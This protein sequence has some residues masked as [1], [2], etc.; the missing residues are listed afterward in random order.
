MGEN[1]EAKFRV[2]VLCLTFER[3]HLGGVCA[4][5]GGTGDVGLTWGHLDT[6]GESAYKQGIN[7]V[8]FREAEK[9]APFRDRFFLVM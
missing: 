5:S 6:W 4:Q 3:G 2:P 8:N 1:D 9:S 7:L